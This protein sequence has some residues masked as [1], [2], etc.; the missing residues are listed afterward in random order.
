MW[1]SG[2]V[3]CLFFRWY[4]YLRWFPQRIY[5]CNL[6]YEA[7]RAIHL[8][9]SSR[10][11][12]KT[13]TFFFPVHHLWL[14]CGFNCLIVTRRKKWNRQENTKLTKWR[15]EI[16]QRSLGRNELVHLYGGACKVNENFSESVVSIKAC[17]SWPSQCHQHHRSNCIIT[18]CKMRYAPCD[19]MRI[20]RVRLSAF[21]AHPRF[22][23]SREPVGSRKSL[24]ISRN[25]HKLRR[26]TKL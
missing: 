19:K 3:C 1:G 14:K 22:F 8:W 9:K 25:Q 18:L 10:V 7:K 21:S 23:W 15:K 5:Y 4:L 17:N 6:L 13:W 11:A 24:S 20:L 26:L 16:A 12:A 2:S